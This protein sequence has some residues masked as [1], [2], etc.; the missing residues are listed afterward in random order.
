VAALLVGVIVTLVVGFAV[1]TAQWIR[2]DRHA[3]RE[4]ALRSDMARELYTSDMFA[5]QQ[6]WDAGNVDRMEKL[7]RRHIPIEAGQADW[8]GFEWYVFWRNHQRSRP[9]HTFRVSDTAWLF[10]A[11][12]N[13]RTLA[14]L[15]YV[16]AP[17]PAD[18]RS[19][20]TLWDAATDWKP[21]TFQGTPETFGNAIALSPDGSVFATGRYFDAGE[22][23]PYLITLWDAATARLLR[24]GPDGHEARV[25]MGALAFS[26]DGKKLL[27]GDKDTTVN[28]WDLETGA[29]RT[30]EGHQALC[31]GVAF[32]P[33][34][35]WIASASD[36]G[37]LK[38]WDLK[39]RHEV[40]TIPGLSS[41]SDVAFSPDGRYL[42]ATT[43]SAV[44]MWDL[45]RP[46]EPREIELKG[47]RT[48]GGLQHSFSPDGRYLVA[49]ISDKVRLWEV[50]SGESRAVLRG[51]SNPVFW[52]TFLDGGRMLASGSLDRTVKFWAIGDA[53]TE[54]DLLTAHTGSVESLVFSPDGQTLASGGSDGRI[55]TW[56]MATGRPLVE[57]EAPGVRKPVRSLAISHDG[58]T[59]ADSRV[60]LWD[61]KTGRL[62]EL[63]SADTSDSAAAFSPVAAIVAMARDG[64]TQLW[65]AVTGKPLRPLRTSPLHGV[66]SLAFSPAGRMLGS[67]G[68]DQK[69]TLWE[70]ATG[71]QLTNDLVGHKGGISSL[72]FSP[73][74]RALTSGGYDG[75]V[76]I[77][78]VADPAKPSLRRK[79]EGNAG[80]IWAVA[81]SPDGKSIASGNDDGTV[82]LWDPTTGRE[83]C[84]LVGHTG[85]V[86]TLAFSP[87]GSV[88]ATGD[89]GGTIRLWRR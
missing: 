31:T 29:V 87:D 66:H 82:K 70:V 13:G 62:L 14:T 23:K 34:S 2:A 59:L 15:V 17:H 81:Y 72:A 49:G 56:V 84:T 35:W 88:L 7:L 24:R 78:D 27:W 74:G 41:P 5:I 60:G 22:G 53:L 58:R 86:G 57:L 26:P 69:V 48:G 10:A 61:L 55:R 51:H 3:A 85:K 33:R 16:H 8:R 18:E 89:A 52:T 42:S 64:N 21:R 39:S 19:E 30:F 38:L 80:A 45:T 50:E 43:W 20:I 76:I 79:L 12:P 28:L 73:D 40:H 67:A 63:A 4:A 71:R 11:T 44:R 37:T 65:D 75:T 25:G 36:D 46:K 47:S 6:A 9:I 1:S 77:W 68:E 83:R 32:D 54:R